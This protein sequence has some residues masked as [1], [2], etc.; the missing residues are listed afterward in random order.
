M[1]LTLAAAL[2][3]AIR[4]FDPEPEHLQPQLGPDGLEVRSSRFHDPAPMTGTDRRCLLLLC[5]LCALVSFLGLGRRDTP[6]SWLT[7][8]AGESRTVALAEPGRIARVQLFCG[9]DVG[10]WELEY[11]EDGENWKPAGELVQNYVA[12]LK[13][14][15][16]ENSRT[17]PSS[18]YLRITCL[19]GPATL[20]EIALWDREGKRLTPVDAGALGDEQ[21]CVPEGEH[22]LNSSYFDEIYHVRTAWEHMEGVRPYEVT[23][24]PLGK[25]LISLG[26]RIF[27]VNPFGWRFSGV[28]FGL[29]MLPLLYLLLKNLF[30]CTVTAA[31]VTAVFA[32]DFLRF[33]QTRIATIDT[34][35]VFFILLMYYF[36]YRYFTQPWDTPLRKTLLPLGLCGLSFAL[37][38]AA[39][40]TVFFA[41]AGLALIWAVR[42]GLRLRWQHVNGAREEAVHYLLPTV[43]WSC[44]FFLLLPVL[45]YCLVYLPYGRAAGVKPFSGDYFRIITDNIGYMYRYHSGL[46]ATHPYESRWWQWMLD[47]KPIL[48]YLKKYDDGTRS[49]FGAFGNPLFWWTGL[50]AMVC[51]LVKAL[52]G[53][54]TALFILIGYLSCLLPWLR[55]TRCAFIYHYFPCTPFLALALGRQCSELC[56]KARLR[57][58]ARAFDPW[59]PGL[60]AGCIL[61]FAVFYTVLTGVAA[62]ARFQHNLLGWFHWPF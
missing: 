51:M 61:L 38:V 30:G 41:G 34:Y 10:S 18:R 13:W 40:W 36:M 29:L 43:L 53:D 21:E 26:M 60:A 42:Q 32:F 24:P 5:A 56:R 19:T 39:K 7:L 33:T 8:R 58:K 9:P 45:V 3:F 35:S 17:S 25:L 50:A 20:G 16:L 49:A 11:S 28:L 62:P 12:V 52:R 22:Y 37:G 59:V 54:K 44:V 57:P 23:H 14:Q 46:E 15:E 31:S 1:L 48:Y 55:V 6:E 47:L 2:A 27:G 4:A